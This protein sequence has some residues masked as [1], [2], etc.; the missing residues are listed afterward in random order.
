MNTTRRIFVKNVSTAL[1][2]TYIA[3]FA[4]TPTTK[5][6]E[7]KAE[8][9]QTEESTSLFFKISLAQWSLHKKLKK[10]DL[11]NLDFPKYAQT[12]FGI[13]AVEYVNQFFA[14]K[15]KDTEYL[16][17][18][19]TRTQDLDVENVL[20]MIDNEGNLGDA[21]K[22]KRIKAIENHYKWV[23]AAQYLGC[24]S[25]RVNAYGEGEANEVKT[26]VVDSLKQLTSFA[27]EYDIN[28]IVENHGGYS[29]DAKWLLK[30]INAVN[31]P[32][33]GTLPDFGNFIIDREKNIEY[34][35]YL[36]VE[37]MM[38][39][40]KGVSAKCYDFDAQG[41]ES[42]IDFEKM[43]TIVKAANYK[44]YIGIEYE[45]DKLPEDEGI[46]KAKELLLKVGKKL[47]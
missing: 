37:E 17:E 47:S 44:G 22:V 40:A 32:N 25:I 46:K 9:T 20:I 34:D 14:D 27:K 33:C 19:K 13:N 5:E 21:D 18:L 35:R 1:A 31:Q 15:A 28:I 41:A 7:Q 43:L 10:G 39:F 11:I 6:K 16:K 26:N 23:E 12:E 3:G 8:E 42:L 29:S 2:G 24:H 30:V 45:G 4:C 36:G 38:P